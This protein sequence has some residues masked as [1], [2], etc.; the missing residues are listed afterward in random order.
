MSRG[1]V[2]LVRV[3]AAPLWHPSGRSFVRRGGVW[4]ESAASDEHVDQQSVEADDE[5]ALWDDGAAEQDPYADAVLD[6]LRHPRRGDNGQSARSRMNM[7][8]LFV[9]LPWE[10]LGPR[11]A[12]I[13][14][15]YPGLWQPWVP[16]GRALEAHRRAFERRWV[17]RWGESLVG[18]WAKEFQQ[19]GRPHLHLYIGLPRAMADED[20]AGL[21]ERTLQRHRLERQFGRRDGRRQTPPLG[22]PYGGEFGNWLLG[23]WSAVVG[24][25]GPG[26]PKVGDAL[27]CAAHLLRGAD[28]AVM[29]FSD[30]AEATTDR[31]AVAQYLAREAGKASQKTPP[32][33]FSHVGRYY[34][35]WGKAIGF[36]PETT[37]RALDPLVAAEVEAR[38]VRFVNWRLH[39]LRRGLPPTNG[40]VLRRPGDGVTAFG[41]GPEQAERLLAFAEKAARR[42]Q[43]TGS[44][45][46]PRA[47]VLGPGDVAALLASWDERNGARA[48]PPEQDGA[49][50]LSVEHGGSAADDAG[51]ERVDVAAHRRRGTGMPEDLLDVEQIEVVRS[52]GVDRPMEDPR[53]AAAQVMGAHVSEPRLLGAQHD[54]LGDTAGLL[55]GLAPRKGAGA[56]TRLLT[57]NNRVGP[58]DVA[59][60]GGGVAGEVVADQGEKGRTDRHPAR[61]A[62]LPD[63]ADRRLRAEIEVPDADMH[64]L[65]DAQPREPEAEHECI[66]SADVGVVTDPEQGAVGLVV[67]EPAGGIGALELAVEG[68]RLA[69]RVLPALQLLDKGG[70]DL[71]LADAPA[72]ER[73]DP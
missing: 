2:R 14:L 26:S 43:S 20:F 15:T 73:A 57:T 30:E 11:P 38:L 48:L 28:V 49:P 47:G 52:V 51:L 39:V 22:I 24:T 9:S 62:L 54:E 72:Q 70:F 60:E 53:R 69:Q 6:E 31:T 4:V 41:I 3:G 34:G 1:Y 59:S 61:P 10:L 67:A 7:R 32:P 46:P 56:R 58:L 33:G 37:T 35:V 8:R 25:S 29:F 19:S 40:L 64:D 36:R 65:G 45:R 55:E 13:S 12:L 71:T 27:S 5:L 68:R 23:A 21:R 50:S 63:P 44:P 17:R 42:R 16:D 18:V 66:A